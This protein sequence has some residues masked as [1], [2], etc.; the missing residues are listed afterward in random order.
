[1]IPREISDTGFCMLEKRFSASVCGLLLM[2]EPW[3]LRLGDGE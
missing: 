3:K 1:V 2:G